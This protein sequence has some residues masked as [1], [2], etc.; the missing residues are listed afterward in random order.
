MGASA[1]AQ[2]KNRARPFQIGCM[3]NDRHSLRPSDCSLLIGW[4]C[5]SD[6]I[7][8]HRQRYDDR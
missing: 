2:A 3:W 6:G 8:N 7:D 1:T 4:K 5:L